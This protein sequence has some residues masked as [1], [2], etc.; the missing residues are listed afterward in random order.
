MHSCGVKL[1]DANRANPLRDREKQLEDGCF[2]L[3]AH[4]WRGGEVWHVDFHL[5][6]T[7]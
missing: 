6:V 3:F 7:M 4:R 2:A 1:V 5:V